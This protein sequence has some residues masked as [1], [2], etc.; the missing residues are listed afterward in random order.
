MSVPNI[1]DKNMN[2]NMYKLK[3]ANIIVWGI[4]NTTIVSNAHTT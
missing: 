4:N 2:I 3:S 1:L